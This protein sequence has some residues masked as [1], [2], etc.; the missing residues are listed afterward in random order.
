MLLP[1]LRGRWRRY[2]KQISYATARALSTFN[3]PHEY[4]FIL[5]H[6]RSGSSLLTHILV[7]NPAVLGYGETMTRYADNRD[8]ELLALK[9][10]WVLRRFP[11]RGPERYLLD[12][13]LHDVLLSP[14]ELELLVE[15]NVRL[16][17]LLREPASSIASLI[18]SLEYSPED[19]VRYYTLRLKRLEQLANRAPP[20]HPV[21][22]LTYQD[23]L[24]DTGPTLERLRSFLALQMPLSEQYQILPT[25]GRRGIGDFSSKIRAGRIVREPTQA[26]P[27]AELVPSQWLHQAQET[28]HQTLSRLSRF[29][30][31]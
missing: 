30:S 3:T 29:Q 15:H 13:L 5:S 24:N 22:C 16:I 12:K 28:Y 21:F 17:F 20:G 4:V 31:P 18:R 1:M 2:L 8:F 19:A 26:V 27:V 23:L 25:T 9:I 14:D 11:L 6:M 7:S 10:Q